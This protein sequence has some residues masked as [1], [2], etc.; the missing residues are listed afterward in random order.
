MKFKLLVFALLIVGGL[1]HLSAQSDG[2]IAFAVERMLRNDSRV[3]A[4]GIEVSV[5]GG[6]VTLLGMV[7]SIGEQEAAIED[8]YDVEGV[9][10]VVDDLRVEVNRETTMED[11]LEADVRSALETSTAVNATAI[12]V[13]VNGNRVT[14]SGT[15]P[16]AYQRRRA[17]TLAIEVFGI[18]SVQNELRV[19]A[20]PTRSNTAIWREVRA[21]FERSAVIDEEEIEVFVEDDRVVLSGTVGSRLEARE[22]IQAAELTA[23]V[24]SV[25][26]NL[27][28]QPAVDVSDDRIRERVRSQ[29]QWDPRVDASDISIAVENGTVR[30]RGTVASGAAQSAAVRSTWGV[31]GV[32]DV[33]E[34]LEIVAIDGDSPVARMVE[35][36]IRFSPNVTVDDLE[37]TYADGVVALFGVVEDAWMVSEAV[38]IAEAVGGVED[39]VSNL[40]VNPALDR[41][42][43]EIRRDILTSLRSNT[44]VDESDI[45]VLVNDGI[46]TLDGFVD[47][48]MEREEAYETALRT[49]GVV[50]VRTQFEIVP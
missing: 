49:P 13:E 45:Q 8:A 33:V 17:A 18:T 2:E 43:V 16:T 37:V 21:A 46:V 5:D 39:V 20:A 31:A 3:E 41:S 12:R 9:V 29:L 50:E 36:R 7:D 28:V 24:T 27:V 35:N 44:M 10:A 22:A 4:A 32:V 48:W 40:T 34:E 47:S 30:L 15:V 23:G 25:R 38:D 26:N 14:L 42:D 11:L 6:V 19:Q 1:P